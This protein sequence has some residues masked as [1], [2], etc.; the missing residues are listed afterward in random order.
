MTNRLFSLILISSFLFT[1][2]SK[3]LTPFTE[4]IQEDFGFHEEDLKRIQ[5]YLSDD[6]VL[7]RNVGVEESVIEGGKI[8]VV[9]GRKVEE[10]VF[11]EG[12]PGVVLFSP[13]SQRLAISFEEDTDKFLMF[14]PNPKLGGRYVLL[15]K[16]WNRR[17]GKVTYN[18]RTWRTNSESALSSLLVDLDAYSDISYESKKVKGRKVD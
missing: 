3:Q 6:I 9:D 18:G 13:K 5:F 12:T 4:R 10:V 14:G 15:A 11:E 1:S 8:K 7:E 17:V 2:C 16:D